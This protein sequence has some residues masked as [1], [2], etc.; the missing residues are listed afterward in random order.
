MADEQNISASKPKHDIPTYTR[1]CCIAS[2][3]RPAAAQSHKNHAESVSTAGTASAPVLST[4]E[5]LAAQLHRLISFVRR[6]VQKYVFQ[7]SKKNI[8]SV[9]AALILVVFAFI[10]AEFFSAGYDAYINGVYVATVSEKADLQEAVT[11]LN[12]KITETTGTAG[13]I[14]TAADY[15]FKFVPKENLT[16]NEEIRHNLL[17]FS[18]RLQDAYVIRVDSTP[19][20]TVASLDDANATLDTVKEQ[21]KNGQEDISVEILNDI[22]V[23]ADIVSVASVASVDTAAQSLSAQKDVEVDYIVQADDSL[24]SLAQENDISISDIREMNPGLDELIID[25]DVLRLTQKQP[26][27]DVKTTQNA[28][29]EE[30]VTPPVNEI[31][32]DSL[33]EGTVQ[34]VEAGTDGTKVVNAQITKINGQE[35]DRLVLSESIVAEPTPSSV[36][37]GTRPIPEGIGSGEFVRPY[38]GTVTSRFGSRWGSVHKGIDI[39]GHVGDAV[40][41]SDEGTVTFAGWNDGGYGYL[42]ILDHGNGY[43]TYY[44]HLNEVLV[45]EGDIVEKGYEI[46]KLGNTGRSTGPH[47]HFEVRKNGEPQNPESYCYG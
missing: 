40:Y 24:W 17:A 35:V 45:R 18:D 41:S 37:I 10:L 1:R 27:L 15:V 29:Y 3:E 33:Y 7:N 38:Q 34:V 44:A 5:T 32:D 30:T 21:Y 13:D 20:T 31:K 26:I 43:Q 14:P 22:Q 4:R 12:Q 42:I 39:G 19:I 47:L 8:A 6:S 28:T 25:G 23:D 46:G 16:E 36:R 9:F 2:E 11:Q